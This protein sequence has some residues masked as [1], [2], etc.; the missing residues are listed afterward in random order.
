MKPF[1]VT[2][3]VA[4]ILCG[5]C[6]AVPPVRADITTKAAREAAEFVLEKFGKSAVKEGTE[7]LAVRI[8]QAGVKYGDDAV[9]AVR[10]VG[11][12][13]LVAADEAGETGGKAVMQLAARHGDDGLV[14]AKS[15][16]SLGLYTKYGDDA[17]E[18]MI[19]HP[20]IAEPLIEV[21][22]KQA[23]SAL[24]KLSSDKARQL[25]MLA[26]E[27]DLAKIG[28]TD[29]L[30]ETIGKYGDRSMDFV[31]KHKGALAVTAVLATF[32]AD[33]EPYITGAKE[34]A[35]VTVER[36]VAPIAEA[37][38]EIATT[39]ARNTNWTPIILTVVGIVGALILFKVWR[40]RASQVSGERSGRA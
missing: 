10:K 39:V 28:R 12:R 15:S 29:E 13:A 11:P 40:G 38:K 26:D 5:F 6:A 33:P 2:F 25:A 19:K 30:L 20:G 32:L 21:H 23:A 31:W 35:T 9:A 18:A 3:V 4:A 34:L 36:V 22:G 17:A 24:S 16:K 37:P 8:E 27:G 14:L 7:K 1:R